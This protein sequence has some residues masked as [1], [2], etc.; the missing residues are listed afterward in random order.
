MDD[1]FWIAMGLVLLSIL[2]IAGV[3][4][5]ADCIYEWLGK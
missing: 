4:A 1:A 2:V 3:W 5:I